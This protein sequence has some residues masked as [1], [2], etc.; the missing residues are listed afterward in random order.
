MRMQPA[1]VL[2]AAMRVLAA[3]PGASMAEIAAAAGISRASLHRLFPGRQALVDA[4]GALATQRVWAAIDA[5]QQADD[6]SVPAGL[7]RLTEAIVPLVHEFAFLSRQAYPDPAD[8]SLD[9]QRRAIESAIV[10]LFRRGQ[11]DGTL[12]TDLPPAWL[13]HA[14]RGLLF[15]VA[16]A[17]L[18]GEI[19]PRDASRLVLTT[20][21]RGA[22]EGEGP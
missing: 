10:Q 5:V 1:Q 9:G 8:A 15:G 22:G 7:G 21:L 3:N 19:A 13:L 16:T 4:I 18:G 17:A 14:Y 6:G 11:A 20:F 12:R 2:A